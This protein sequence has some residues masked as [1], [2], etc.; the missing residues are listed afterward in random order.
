MTTASARALAQGSMCDASSGAKRAS[1]ISLT[2]CVGVCVLIVVVPFEALT[3]LFTLPAQSVSSAE[4]VLLAVLAGWVIACARAGEWPR[5]RTA[6]TVPW[7]L[8][9]AASVAAAIGASAFHA[10]AIGMSARLALALAVFLVAVHGT[11]SWS[12]IQ[13]VSITAA[14]AGVVLSGLVIADYF[15]VGFVRQWLSAFREGVALVGAQVRASG[16]FQYPT[17]ASMY[18]EILFALALPQ[19]VLALDRRRRIWAVAAAALLL[20]VA[21]ANALTFTRAGLVTMVTSLVIVTW[22][23]YRVHGIDGVVGAL[24]LFAAVITAQFVGSRSLEAMALR[25][26][27][28]GQHEWYQAWIEAP[29]R[30]DVATGAV[31]TVP[32]TL[33]NTGRVTWD[34]TLA[35]PFRVSSHWLNEDGTRVVSWEGRRTDFPRPVGPG[36][37]VTLPV[38]VEAPRQP[39]QYRLMWDVELQDR[40]W[41][42]TEP[43]AARFISAVSVSGPIVGP[44][45]PLKLLPHPLRDGSVRSSRLLLWRAGALMFREHPWLGVGPDNYR[46]L[47]GSYLGLAAFDTRVHSNNLY[48][49]VLIG[50]GVIGA[51]AFALLLWR[52]GAIAFRLVRRVSTAAAATSIPREASTLTAGVV[53]AVAAIA[54]HGLVDSFLSFTATYVLIAIALGLLVAGESLSRPHAY[55]V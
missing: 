1:A 19:F 20:L 11:T 50:S 7:M 33:T 26:T 46:L 55:R 42:S 12:R 29:T 23:R 3:P 45:G 6:L 44:A 41:F 43:D 47:Y 21:Q 48:L 13:V 16:P 25:L 10:N 40:L 15:A 53:A 49:E 17:I 39:G 38:D 52:A 8:W 37:R 5:W 4:A 35:Q 54:L 34:S 2:A 30:L 51:T 24:A 36:A 9:I 18:L 31:I 28:E 22:F 32:I 14:V 27:S